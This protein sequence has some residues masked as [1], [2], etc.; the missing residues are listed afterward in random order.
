[1][2]LPAIKTARRHA[3]VLTCMSNLRQLG[4]GFATYV[5]EHDV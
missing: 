4:I 3:R 1:M 5:G 2:L